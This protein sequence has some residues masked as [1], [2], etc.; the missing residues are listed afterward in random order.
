[1]Q[2][3]LTSS[4]DLKLKRVALNKRRLFFFSE[5]NWQF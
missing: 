2:S 5:L 1:V 3:R 4:T